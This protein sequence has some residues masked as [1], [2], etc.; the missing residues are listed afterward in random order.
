M[1]ATVLGAILA[2]TAALLGRLLGRLL[3]ATTPGTTAAFECGGGFGGF[4]VSGGFGCFVFG[5]DDL[6]CFV[7]DYDFVFDYGYGD[8]MPVRFTKFFF[9]FCYNFDV[10]YVLDCH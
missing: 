9:C 2:R 5:F 10:A 3:L 1:L 8:Y 6:G 4:G 7:F